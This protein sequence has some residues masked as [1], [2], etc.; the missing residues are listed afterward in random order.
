MTPKP[1]IL[2]AISKIGDFLGIAQLLEHTVHYKNWKGILENF[3][4]YHFSIS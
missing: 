3:K 2:I 4:A 1:D